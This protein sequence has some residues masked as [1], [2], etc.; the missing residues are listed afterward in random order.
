VVIIEDLERIQNQI[1]Q[2]LSSPIDTEFRIVFTLSTN[3]RHPHRLARVLKLSDTE[4][5][6]YI[7]KLSDEKFIPWNRIQSKTKAK[8][9]PFPRG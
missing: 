7:Y 4:V 8:I 5:L 1:T 6:G 2:V 3:V 9:I